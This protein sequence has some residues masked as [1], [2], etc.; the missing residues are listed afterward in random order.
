MTDDN[1]E[2]QYPLRQNDN[3]KYEKTCPVCGE[4]FRT[5]NK[6]SI[7]CTV[8]H[9]KQTHNKRHYQEHTDQIIKRVKQNRKDQKQ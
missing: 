4:T 6:R 5:N 8:E 2:R 7:Y 9:R 3:G 1:F